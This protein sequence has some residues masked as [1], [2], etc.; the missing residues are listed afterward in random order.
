MHTG[1]SVWFA[2]ALEQSWRALSQAH[3]GVPWMIPHFR[4]RRVGRRERWRKSETVTSKRS[5]DGS[6]SASERK[7]RD[8][9]H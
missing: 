3:I 9:F 1:L 4:M 6:P 8:G 2:G 7:N 5:W